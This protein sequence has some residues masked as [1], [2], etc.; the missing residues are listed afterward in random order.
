MSY[1]NM[2]GALKQYRRIGVDT[3]IPEATPH[4]RVQLLLEG[5]LDRVAVATGC[6]ERGDIPNK[7]AQIGRAVSIIDNL[8]AALDH[9]VGGEMA[10]NLDS[11]YVYMARRLTEANLHN[12]VAD[13]QEVAALVREIKLGWDAIPGHMVGQQYAAATGA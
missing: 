13:L 6:I 10:G 5:V 2:H 12:R 9:E 11:L 4:R 8:R 7:G 1:A 3:E